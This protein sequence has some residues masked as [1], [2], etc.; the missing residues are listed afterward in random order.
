MLL[1]RHNEDPE[2]LAWNSYAGEQRAPH[3]SPCANLPN[4]PP[5]MKLYL[6]SIVYAAGSLIFVIAPFASFENLTTHGWVI[7]NRS[8]VGFFFFLEGLLIVLIFGS[9]FKKLECIVLRIFS[10]SIEKFEDYVKIFFFFF[11]SI[12]IQFFFFI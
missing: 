6:T 3:K 1:F 11:Y 8:L 7:L 10:K 4:Y 5:W 12:F 2:G 9:C